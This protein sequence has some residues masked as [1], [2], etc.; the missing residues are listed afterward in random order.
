M[1]SMQDIKVLK[2]LRLIPRELAEL[3]YDG[4]ILTPGTLVSDNVVLMFKDYVRPQYMELVLQD[5]PHTELLIKRTPQ[6]SAHQSRKYTCNWNHMYAAK[7]LGWT[8]FAGTLV[9]IAQQVQDP[10]V[11]YCFEALRVRFLQEILID[12]ADNVFVSHSAGDPALIIT[13]AKKRMAAILIG[14]PSSA[15][16]IDYIPA[17]REYAIKDKERREKEKE[18]KDGDTNTDNNSGSILGIDQSSIPVKLPDMPKD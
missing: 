4:N 13:T 6:E 17:A 5:K 12:E 9:A 2:P 7:I 15:F 14:L 10:A 16:H 3:V 18:N 8:S 1:N 11:F